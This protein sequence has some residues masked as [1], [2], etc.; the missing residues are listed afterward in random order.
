MLPDCAGQLP[1][2]CSRYTKRA[3]MQTKL[4]SSSCTA[5]RIHRLPDSY[6]QKAF[7][8]VLKVSP[9]TSVV[10]W[11]P[12]YLKSHFCGAP[13][14]LACDFDSPKIPKTKAVLHFRFQSVPKNR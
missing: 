10:M 2:A 13:D 8:V 5:E 6:V 7:Q 1:A 11:F 14:R 4:K 3:M 9:R 12:N